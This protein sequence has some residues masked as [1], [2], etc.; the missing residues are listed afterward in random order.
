VFL[1]VADLPESEREAALSRACGD[2]AALRSEIEVLLRADAQA[3]SPTMFKSDQPQ[4]ATTL[5]NLADLRKAQ[6]RVADGEALAR[7]SLEMLD[8]LYGPDD[9][10]SETQPA[11]RDSK[12]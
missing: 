7:Q 8:R 9:V 6:G 11:T 5:Q 12:R 2:D 1:E 4:I 10:V 3:A